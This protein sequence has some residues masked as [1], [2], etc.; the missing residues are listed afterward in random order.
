MRGGFELGVPSP[1]TKGR[2]S[3]PQGKERIMDIIEEIANRVRD[4]VASYMLSIGE[5]F[6][7]WQSLAEAIRVEFL[8]DADHIKDKIE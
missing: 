3:P 8:N 5:D 1:F 2:V 4:R 6:P 7:E